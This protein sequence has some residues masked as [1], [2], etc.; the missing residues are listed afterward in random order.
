MGR[1]NIVFASFIKIQN[2]QMWETFRKIN[3]RQISYIQVG[4]QPTGAKVPD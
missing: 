3:Q 4:M 1:I 2:L